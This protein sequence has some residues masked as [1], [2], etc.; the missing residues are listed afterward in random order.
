MRSIPR[1]QRRAVALISGGLDSMLAARVVQEQGIHVEGV[2]FFTGFCVE[3]HT[4]SIRDRKHEKPKRNNALWVAEQLGIKLHII[5][6]SEDY[7]DVVLHPRHGYGQNLNPCLDCKIFM[8]GKTLE[9]GLIDDLDFDFVLTGEVIG[10]RPKSQRRETM[11]IIAK[12]SG[13]NDRLLRPLCALNLPPTLPEREGWVNRNQ[14]FGFHGRSRKPQMELAE[15]FGFSDY[16]QPAGGCCFL[17]D[18][19]YSNKLR[20]LWE[21][22]DSRDY[23]LDDIMLLKIGRHIRPRPHFKLII[24]R[25]EGENRF[26][27]GYRNQFTHLVVTDYPGPLALIDGSPT[28]TDIELAARIVARYSQGRAADKLLVTVASATGLTRDIEVTPMAPNEL[29]PSWHVGS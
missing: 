7:K 26:L 20:D 12:E 19:T 17:T 25:E 5:D 11:P 4:H 3:G 2:N 29:E 9:L 22:R 13:A 18:E 24:G 1:P 21:A 14:L 10:Q 15:K 23:Q 8:V 6:I 16:A 28:T 27:A